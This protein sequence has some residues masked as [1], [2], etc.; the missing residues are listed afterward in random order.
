MPWWIAVILLFA[1]GILLKLGLD[2]IER[3]RRK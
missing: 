2:Y 1:T 3:R